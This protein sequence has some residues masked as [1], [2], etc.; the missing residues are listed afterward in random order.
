MS[1]EV[2]K[3]LAPLNPMVQI[4][5]W[6]KAAPVLKAPWLRPHECTCMRAHTHV[7]TWPHDPQ[8]GKAISSWFSM[9]PQCVTSIYKVSTR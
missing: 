9:S 7:Q 3:F 1:G 4:C 8:D 5:P 6:L 2:N